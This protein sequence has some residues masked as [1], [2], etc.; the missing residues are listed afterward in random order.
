MGNPINVLMWLIK[1]FNNRNITLKA[2]DRISLG[3]VGKLFP[4]KKNTQY[5]YKFIGF[6]KD[7]SLKVNIN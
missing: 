1:D 6:K 7:L 4:I 5:T 2:N 3:S